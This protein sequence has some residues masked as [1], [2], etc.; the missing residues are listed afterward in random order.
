VIKQAALDEAYRRHPERFVNG[1]PK[2]KSPPEVVSINPLPATV[3]EIP[4]Q[5]NQEIKSQ[6]EKDS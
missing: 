2:T 4:T 5:R 6:T 3:I 1:A